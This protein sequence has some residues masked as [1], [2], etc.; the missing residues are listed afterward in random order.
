MRGQTRRAGTVWLILALVV[1]IAACGPDG[2]APAP[3]P[4]ASPS[5][6]PPTPLPPTWTPSAV[7]PT[8]TS[9]TPTPRPSVTPRSSQTPLPEPLPGATQVDD[10]LVVTVTDESLN[11]ALA[12]Q[13]AA[14]T[15][16]PTS[17]P[18]RVALE[19]GGRARIDLVF[20]NAFLERAGQVSTV[21][22]LST[23]GG[24]VVL[25][26][27]PGERDLSGALVGEGAIRAGLALVAD[28]LNAALVA[29]AG[30][31]AAWMLAGLRVYP[32]Y[33]EADYAPVRPVG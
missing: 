26:E 24:Q 18:P 2:A 14:L 19:Y 16:P 25:A 9:V 8:P 15:D 20:Y 6:E 23:A 17:D 31:A 21:A 7:P 11:T 29:Q 22:R 4:T 32:G 3:T 33:L 30:D 1:T 13:H 5:P 10:A 27:V 12:A 28:G